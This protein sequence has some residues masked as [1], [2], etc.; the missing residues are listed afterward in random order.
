[1]HYLMSDSQPP[2]HRSGQVPGQPPQQLLRR[3]SRGRRT[4]EILDSQA[5]TES[6]GSITG[7]STTK[8]T[9]LEKH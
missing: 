2:P 1:M 3:H 8:F 9:A 7:T 4:N 6:L 5:E